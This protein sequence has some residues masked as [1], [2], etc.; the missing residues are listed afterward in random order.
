MG[1]KIL[2]RMYSDFLL[3]SRLEEYKNLI[4]NALTN[5]YSVISVEQFYEIGVMDK[6]ADNA[7][8]LVLRHDI[9][10][11]VTTARMF[12]EIEKKLEVHSS[13]YF[14][15][16]TIDLDLMREI[17]L[18]GSEVSYH[19]EEIASYAKYYKIRNREQI[20][21]N[22]LE[23]QEIFSSNLKNLRKHTGLPMRIV[24]AHGDFVNRKLRIPN[25]E[26]LLDLEFRR[27]NNIKLEV[28][29]ESIM[30]HV[31]SRHSD[32]GYPKFWDSGSPIE[33]IGNGSP[34]I[35]VLTHPRHWRT[36][37]KENIKNNFGRLFEGLNYK[38]GYSS[39]R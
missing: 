34:V 10:T 9:D 38:M 11:D 18:Y 1:S 24:A 17:N 5:N 6:Q 7:K 22:M 16:S 33:S 20:Y 15:L 27:N 31:T 26:I 25:Y 37:I 14:R 21:S 3:P 30:K 36:N 23:I 35:Y 39:E 4:I 29:D 12:F 13:F 19:F 8:Y 32:T 2:R 28:Y